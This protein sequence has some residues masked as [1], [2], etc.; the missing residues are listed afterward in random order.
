[1]VELDMTAIKELETRWRAEHKCIECGAELS[2]KDIRSRCIRCPDHRRIYRQGLDEKRAARI[3]KELIHLEN[4]RT[5]CPDCGRLKEDEGAPRCLFCERQRR[6]QQ[7]KA[8]RSR[9][10]KAM[11]RYVTQLE[12]CRTCYWATVHDGHIFCPAPVGTCMK[13]DFRAMW[14]EAKEKRI[15]LEQA[16]EKDDERKPEI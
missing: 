1:M 5:L 8:E 2:K 11:E 12:K 4:A 10:E 14:K 13:G 3:R 9:A 7:I 6:A 15:A 16:K